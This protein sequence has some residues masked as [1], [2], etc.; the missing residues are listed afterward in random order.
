[1]W[2]KF[3]MS[4]RFANNCCNLWKILQSHLCRNWLLSCLRRVWFSDYGQ[5]HWCLQQFWSFKTWNFEGNF[6]RQKALDI[7]VFQE[8]IRKRRVVITQNCRTRRL[9]CS[10][11]TMA[12]QKRL[13]VTVSGV[14]D[15]ASPFFQYFKWQVWAGKYSRFWLCKSSLLSKKRK[16]IRLFH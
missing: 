12:L 7:P 5:V 8:Q 13:P 6:F 2:E 3:E 9:P 11:F 10:A 15:L 14:S 1:M 16:T 4:V